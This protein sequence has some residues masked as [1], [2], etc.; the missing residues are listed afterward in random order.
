MKLLSCQSG[1][2]SLL[3]ACASAGESVDSAKLSHITRRLEVPLRRGMNFTTGSY[4]C[5]MSRSSNSV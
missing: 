3:V 4:N 2:S 5:F 1:K